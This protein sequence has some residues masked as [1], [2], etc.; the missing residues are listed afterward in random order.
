MNW[1]DNVICMPVV[2]SYG[3]AGMGLFCWAFVAHGVTFGDPDI[4]Y[5][6]QRWYNVS[7]FVDDQDEQYTVEAFGVEELARMEEQAEL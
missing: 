6:W 7:D 3:L 1:I 4:L 5:R 2:I